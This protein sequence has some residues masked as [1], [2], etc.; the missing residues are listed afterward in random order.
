MSE[1]VYDIRE[2]INS[3]TK[4]VCG[5]EDLDLLLPEELKKKFQEM[6]LN[7]QGSR[8][9]LTWRL[10]YNDST[11]K[12]FLANFGIDVFHPTVR[13]AVAFDMVKL[14]DDS[15]SNDTEYTY[16]EHKAYSPAEY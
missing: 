3:A 15:V 6:F 12:K 11:P 16:P 13:D 4:Y 14:D 2:E 10:R 8:I 9:D 5:K 1:T 7:P